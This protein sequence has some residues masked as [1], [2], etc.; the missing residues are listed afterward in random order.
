MSDPIKRSW[1]DVTEGFTNLGKAVKD[2][3][4]GAARSG[5]EAA[6]ATKEAFDGL[7]DVVRQ[8]G[9]KLAGVVKDEDLRAQTSEAMRTLSNA[10][11]VTVDTIG[12]QVGGFFKRKQMHTD[13]APRT[14]A[15]DTDATDATGEPVSVGVPEETPEAVRPSATGLVTG[16]LD[17][18]TDIDVAE[19]HIGEGE[20][21]LAPPPPPP[22]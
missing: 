12:D 1:D 11:T 15:V 4:D 8:L 2:R 19:V 22:G 21:P 3:Y 20:T 17:G 10:L 5:T 18:P 9:D 16:P 13:D 7:A 14:D 6:G